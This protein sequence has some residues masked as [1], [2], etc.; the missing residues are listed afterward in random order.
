V[1]T[2]RPTAGCQKATTCAA[3]LPSP[4]QSSPTS[5]SA[6]ASPARDGKPSRRRARASSG[7]YPSTLY[8][9][10]LIGPDTVSTLAPASIEALHRGEGNQRPNSVTENVDEALR[11]IRGLA[12]AGV[13][14]DDV[15]ATLE[16]EGVD[17]FAVS[18][19]DALNTIEKR[20]A[21]ITS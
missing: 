3:R 11:V 19:R 17:S 15:T 7:A 2:P 21:E 1:S 9:D 16:R 10:E 12:D 20:R 5:C 14:F 8:I 6:S 4:T 18:F 13:D